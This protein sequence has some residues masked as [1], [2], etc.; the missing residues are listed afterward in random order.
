MLY[1]LSA[2]DGKFSLDNSSTLLDE[3]DMCDV[4][5]TH[6]GLSKAAAAAR[7][8][9]ARVADFN[10]VFL[11]DGIVKEA[12]TGV[13]V[14]MYEVD[15]P[16]PKSPLKQTQELAHY[17]DEQRD[18]VTQYLFPGSEVED[19]LVNVQDARVKHTKAKFSPGSSW[20]EVL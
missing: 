15:Y 4:L 7:L 10:T 6:F 9:E 1:K 18:F 5:V 3:Y 17:L 14:D 19:I 13:I 16:T 20:R 12:D 2:I 8:T 11:S